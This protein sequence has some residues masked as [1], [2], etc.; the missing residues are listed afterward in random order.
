MGL[1]FIHLNL[2]GPQEIQANFVT[3]EKSETRVRALPGLPRE[4]SFEPVPPL[5]GQSPQKQTMTGSKQAQDAGPRPGDRADMGLI[6]GLSGSILGDEE[7]LEWKPPS[8]L[9]RLL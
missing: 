3:L 9:T 2:L 4:L 6:E 5:S 8:D 7:M 1:T